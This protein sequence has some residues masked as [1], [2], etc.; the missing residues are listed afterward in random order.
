EREIESHPLLDLWMRPN[1][2]MGTAELIEQLFGFWHLDGNTY[3]WANRPN[4][5]QPPVELWLL[6][7]DLMKI[8][9]GQ[10]DVSGYVY[11]W[12]TPHA[13]DFDIDQIMH[14]KFTSYLDSYYGLSPIEVAM[15]TVDQ[16]NAGN[17]WNLA[18]MQNDA[19]PSGLFKAKGYLTTEQ[20]TQVHRELKR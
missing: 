13:Q 8:V 3:L 19:R 11:G 15:R 5:R 14:L 4:P 9:A 12:G 7:P 2:R 6:R 1:P 16:M 10:L 18:L 17:E 20:R